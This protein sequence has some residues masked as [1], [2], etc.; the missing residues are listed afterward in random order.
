MARWLRLLTNAFPLW[1]VLA[2]ILA[3]IYPAWFTWFGKDHLVIGLAVIM[4]GMGITLSMED[5]KRVA[6]MPRA[7]LTGFVA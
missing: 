4:L 2:G 7:I 5:F 6:K 1:V 3:L